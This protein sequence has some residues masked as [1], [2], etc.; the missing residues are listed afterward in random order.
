LRPG[1]PKNRKKSVGE[2]KGKAVVVTGAGQGLGRAYALAIA[3]AGGQVVVND[4]DRTNAEVV[5][6]EIDAV[7]GEAI[8]SVEAVGTPESADRI[9]SR[10]LAR[11]GSIHGLIN[12]AAMHSQRPSVEEAPDTVERLLRANVLGTWYTGLSA[13]AAM[14]AAGRGVVINVASGAMLGSPTMAIYGASKAAV[15]SLTVS[16]ARELEGSGVR[17]M[18]ISPWARTPMLMKA[19]SERW[20]EHGPEVAAPLAVYL[21]T[22][23]AAHL[24]GQ[25]VRIAEGQISLYSPGIYGRVLGTS[26]EWTSDNIHAVLAD[27]TDLGI[28]GFT[29]RDANG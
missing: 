13:I 28:R 1:R 23:R 4:L 8:V 10:C 7:G 22:D 5:A 11:F 18:G 16:W 19:S 27:Q 25:L 29:P 6:A 14:R 20:A 9:V 3:R 12:N 2:L 17:V 24:N 21:L 15:Q 26:L